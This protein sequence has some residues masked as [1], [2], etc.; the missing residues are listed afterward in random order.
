MKKINGKDWIIWL[1]ELNFCAL[2]NN[3]NEQTTSRIT[4]MN[5]SSSKGFKL[6]TVFFAV[7]VLAV[8]AMLSNNTVAG[9]TEIQVEESKWIWLVKIK[10]RD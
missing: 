7:A 10:P 6:T 2:F 4:K 9:D 3:N 5:K 8:S 1:N